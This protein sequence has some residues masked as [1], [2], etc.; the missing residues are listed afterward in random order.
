[1][2]KNHSVWQLLKVRFKD[3]PTWHQFICRV[4]IEKTFLDA[5]DLDKAYELFLIEN[6]LSDKKELPKLTIDDVI[7]SKPSGLTASVTLSEL[8]K[9]ENINAIPH[10]SVLP[11]S[12]GLTIIYGRNGAGKSGYARVL[13]SACFSRIGKVVIEP[14]IRKAD[15]HSKAQLAHIHLKGQTDPILFTPGKTD[16]SLQRIAFFDSEA[17]GNHVAGAN[18]IEFI[19]AGMDVLDEE[20]RCFNEL[21]ERLEKELFSKNTGNP[22]EG[23]FEGN[24]F[25]RTK[26]NTLSAETDIEEL[27][28]LAEFGETEEAQL[29][30]ITEEYKT[31]STNEKAFRDLKGTNLPQLIAF[32]AKLK[33]LSENFSTA[34][35]EE[36]KKLLTDAEGK[37]KKAAELQEKLSIDLTALEKEWREFLAS[38]KTLAQKIHEHYPT[39]KDDCLLCGRPLDTPEAITRIKNFW[40]FLQ[41]KANQEYEASIGLVN[42]KIK[43]LNGLRFDIFSTSDIVHSFVTVFAHRLNRSGDRRNFGFNLFIFKCGSNLGIHHLEE[44]TGIA[45]GRT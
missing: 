10:T 2:T 4:A 9:L 43:A 39:D 7:P 31:L 22:F 30:A 45:F 35:I 3:L 34:K 19:P 33:V 25:V 37:R 40:E 18:A 16:A 6:K 5:K 44:N 21:K 24:S 26:I 8:K 41:G 42:T 15:A 38:G 11:F 20:I 13:K 17:A 14:D 28:K 27:K 1:M 32:I 36:L 12:D 23:R 29:V